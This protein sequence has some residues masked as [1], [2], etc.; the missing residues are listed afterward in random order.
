[1][2]LFNKLQ[3]DFIKKKGQTFIFII[4]SAALTTCSV[5][6]SFSQKWLLINY[7]FKT[8]TLKIEMDQKIFSIYLNQPRLL[9]LKDMDTFF[10]YVLHIIHI[11]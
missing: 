7:F 9:L 10:M 6:F 4:I 5:F 8:R 3:K 1:M 2:M 11:I